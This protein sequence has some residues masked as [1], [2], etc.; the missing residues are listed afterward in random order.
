[1]VLA[2][3]FALATADF[4]LELVRESL[5]GTH[6]RYREYV[7]GLPTENFIVSR[8]RG[9]AAALE[10]Q[11]EAPGNLWWIDGRAVRR[12][13]V[14][15]SP[16]KPWRHDYDAATGALLRRTPLFFH[17]KPARVFD[18]NPVV[19]LND[20]SLQDLNDASAHIPPR[21]YNDVLLPDAALSGPFA[22]I[23]DRQPPHVPPATGSLVFDR[24]ADGFEDVSAY[25]HID[26]MQRHVRSLGYEGTRAIAG[27]AIDVDAHAASGED[28]SFFIP[29]T[30]TPGTG[31]LFYGEGGTDDAEDADIVVHEYGHA[32]TEW[33]SPGTWGASSASEA[34][35]ISEAVSDY[36]A[37]SAHYDARRRSGRDPFC[38]ADWD[39]RCWEDAASERC[40]Y[41][42][43]SDCLRRV[44]SGATMADY[45]RND[46]SGVEHRN[47]A[48]LSSALREIRTRLDRRSADRLVL[49]SL[50]ATPPRP[51]FASMA[52]RLIEAD[53]VL[54][55]GAN[56]SLICAVMRARGI[57]DDCEIVPRGEITLFQS[58][59]RGLP[60]PDL[61][62]TASTLTISDRRVIANVYVRVDIAHSARGDLRIEL[63][64]PGG[65]SILLQP[66]TI[67]IES[68]VHVTYGLTAPSAEPLDVLRGRRAEGTWTLV[69][70]DRRFRDAGRLL[71]WG[72][73]I[74]FAGEEPRAERPRG[75]PSQMIPVAGH[76]WGEPGLFASDLRISN[77][78]ATPR[79]A[80]LIFTPSGANGLEE[81]A[82][83]QLSLAPGQTL[84]FDDVVSSVFHT[85]G[86][87][88]LEIVGDVIAMSRTYLRTSQGTFGQQVPPNL[89]TT[90]EGGAPLSLA[91]VA[92]SLSGR[93]WRPNLGITETAGGEGTAFVNG[94]P[95]PVRP[96]SHVQFPVDVRTSRFA[97]TVTGTARIAAYLSEV[98]FMSGDPVF[99]AGEI[100]PRDPRTVIA[101]VTDV[102]DLRAYAT[103][104][105]LSPFEATLLFR[106]QSRT[107]ILDPAPATVFHWLGVARLIAA[108]AEVPAAL[109]LRLPGGT[110]AALHYPGI[111]IPFLDPEGAGFQHLTFI[112]ND[113]AYRAQ[114]GVVS[115]GAVTA[116]VTVFD[117]AGAELLRRTL[118]GNGGTLLLPDVPRVTHGRAVVR[119]LAGSGRAFAIVH[120]TPGDATF[121]APR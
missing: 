25:F 48:I 60:I 114:I 22:R 97:I 44:D 66:E 54:H 7:H 69:V 55:R 37:F 64:A 51:T 90:A 27:Y 56:A 30:T 10:A 40:A 113:D 93:A 62:Q 89:D 33:I 36:L 38:L 105:S 21:A 59:E 104:G 74:E 115:E 4:R 39:A 61:G 58:R 95:V 52:R 31:T 3:L 73:E 112:E 12:E 8:C 67:S 28:N 45:N 18:P 41:P 121:I 43:G 96:F 49:E 119:F 71:S 110:G 91:P 26:R 107:R 88:S 9:N 13:I 17:V 2:A 92:F 1:M 81:F 42:P 87:G 19:V 102:V 80:T 70:S 34:R 84:A 82:A 63:I 108:D 106:D 116:E 117:A 35:A 24:T 83:V 53:A 111:A 20:P 76:L 5:T 103:A 101:P 72:L 118:S 29:S 100:V 109:R 16:L 32:L 85:G 46:T 99:V 120:A 23:I 65:T 77:P 75:A 50:F 6:C 86:S 68:D 47:S 98:D 11:R 57:L 14:Y 15:E 79:T 94:A 78:R